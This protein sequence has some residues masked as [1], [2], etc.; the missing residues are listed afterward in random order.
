MEAETVS[1][2]ANCVTAVVAIGALAVTSMGLELTKQGLDLWRQ[3]LVGTDEYTIAKKL[4]RTLL[5]TKQFLEFVD[6]EWLLGVTGKEIDN[7]KPEYQRIRDK[8]QDCSADA[9]ILWGQ[10]W[11]TE[12]F[13]E[14]NSK[15]I[16][17]TYDTKQLSSDVKKRTAAIKEAN[18]EIDAL[19]QRLRRYAV[20]DERE[21]R[22]FP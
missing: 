2:I 15:I 4:I 5:D 9:T 14:I 17:L 6:I 13:K 20:K 1:A 22:M 8:I 10:E 18:E 11:S 16:N 7:I 12:A 3:Q 19:I 21:C